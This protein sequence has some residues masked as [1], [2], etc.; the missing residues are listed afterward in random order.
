MRRTPMMNARDYWNRR[1]IGTR[2]AIA[3]GVAGRAAAGRGALAGAVGIHAVAG[4]GAITRA[5]RRAVTATVRLGAR[6]TVAEVVILQVLGEI[7]QVRLLGVESE[8]E[9]SFKPHTTTYV[10]DGVQ[11]NT[12]NIWTNT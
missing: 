12:L 5:V 8:E 6:G 11:I 10:S 1:R 4:V 3:I 9:S 2:I 7:V